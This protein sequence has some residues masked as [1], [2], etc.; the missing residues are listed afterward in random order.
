[1]RERARQQALV[2]RGGGERMDG[3]EGR[4]QQRRRGRGAPVATAIGEELRVAGAQ[5][6]VALGVP[7]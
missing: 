3:G 5:L 6:G 4:L 2:V 1:M 7:A